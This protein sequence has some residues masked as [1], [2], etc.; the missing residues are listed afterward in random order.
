MSDSPP[1]RD[2]EWTASGAEAAFKHLSPRLGAVPTRSAQMPADH[3]A[4]ATR[5][6]RRA[7]AR[8]IDEV[9]KGIEGFAFN[10]A[11]AK[12]YDFTNTL[13]QANASTAAMKRRRSARWRS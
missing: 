7:T 3:R 8:A 1:E 13:S 12:L 10:K 11:I 6:W 9:T 4:M 2:V 5:T